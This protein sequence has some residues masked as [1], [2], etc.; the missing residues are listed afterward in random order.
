[1][2]D[3]LEIEADGPKALLGPFTTIDHVPRA[4]HVHQLRRGVATTCW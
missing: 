1:V 3:T 2:A 4:M